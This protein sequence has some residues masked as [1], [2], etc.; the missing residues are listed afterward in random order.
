[1]KRFL[2]AVLTVALSV[3]V[4]ADEG[5]WTFD[6]VPKAEI[7]KRYGV[8]LSDQWLARVQRSVVR[9]EIG[10][11]RVVRV[12]G[13]S[14]SD[15]PPLCRRVPRRELERSARSRG[16]WATCGARRERNEVPGRASLGLDEHRKH[17]DR[18]TKAI[19]DVEPAQATAARNEV[20]TTL[21]SRMRG[22]VEESRHA[23]QVRERLALS[24]RPVPGST[25][26]SATTMCVWRLRRNRRWR[27]S[28]ATR[29]TSSSRA[30]ASTCRCCAPTR[31]AS[32]P[33]RRTHLTFNWAGA[34][35]KEA[36]LRRRPSRHDAAAADRR[37]AQDASAISCCRSGCCASPSCAAG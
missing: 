21:E 6:N 17:H 25:S 15:E 13:G 28:A 8:Q 11:H 24:G 22:G 9:L 7:A 19:G 2:L 36:G 23:A 35:E 29:T 18:V 14:R 4:K 1:M 5:M 33:R 16:Q 31:T 30:G 20:L 10:L 27:R 3:G 34:R 37:A 32:R 12:I 26:T